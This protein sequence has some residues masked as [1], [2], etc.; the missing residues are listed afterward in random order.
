[1]ILG[2]RRSLNNSPILNVAAPANHEHKRFP[3]NNSYLGLI[4]N[5]HIAMD[6]GHLEN[7]NVTLCAGYQDIVSLNHR[8]D[9]NNINRH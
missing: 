9:V 6:S 7:I 5:L 8:L 3:F 2:L 4:I 1:M